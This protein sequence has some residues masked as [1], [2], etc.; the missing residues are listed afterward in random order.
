M[1]GWSAGF[2]FWYEG[3][4]IPVGS[5]RSVLEIAAW[6]SWAAASMLR[7]RVNWSVM[8][9]LPR[10]DEEVIWSTPAIVENC[11]SSGVATADA[12]VSGLAPGRLAFT[13]IVGKSTYGRLLTDERREAIYHNMNMPSMKSVVITGSLIDSQELIVSHS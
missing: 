7:S 5:C 2:T 12:M 9:V 13:W 1:I 4:T 3:G 8:L 11:F 6:M 10:L